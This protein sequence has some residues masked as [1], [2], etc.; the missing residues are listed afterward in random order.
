MAPGGDRALLRCR[1][2]APG[3]RAPY[4]PIMAAPTEAV[5]G[6][7]LAQGLQV[8]PSAEV[9]QVQPAPPVPS[10]PEVPSLADANDAVAVRKASSQ[11]LRRTMP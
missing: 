7:S 1:D 10:K 5:P 4:G 8:P 11:P 9:A 2:A 6:A 3:L